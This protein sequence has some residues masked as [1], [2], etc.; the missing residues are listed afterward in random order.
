MYNDRKLSC[1]LFHILVDTLA[2]VV[3]NAVV[4][5]IYFV[6]DGVSKP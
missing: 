1:L 6:N 4:T 5:P 3:L 2:C